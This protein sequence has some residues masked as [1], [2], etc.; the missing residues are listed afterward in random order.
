MVSKKTKSNGTSR[1]NSRKRN[2][3]E[4]DDEGNDDGGEIGCICEYEDDDGFMIQ[5]EQCLVWQ[6]TVCVGIS[7][8]NIPEQYYCEK[9]K[10]R[11]VDRKAA[12]EAQK[13]SRLEM[14][15]KSRSRKNSK[16]IGETETESSDTDKDPSD[17]DTPPAGN[18]L[19]GEDK[20]ERDALASRKLSREEKKLQQILESFA[21]HEE[22]EKR[23]KRRPGPGLSGSES[24]P[25]K[26]KKRKNSDASEN[27]EPTRRKKQ[28]L[29]NGEQ[30]DKRRKEKTRP[31]SSPQEKNNGKE[32]EPESPVQAKPSLTP[33]STPVAAPFKTRKAWMQKFLNETKSEAP[34]ST[35]VEPKVEAK[36]VYEAKSMHHKKKLAHLF[37]TEVAAAAASTSPSPSTSTTTTTDPPPAS[38]PM[39]IE[40]M[41]SI[42]DSVSAA[43]EAKAASNSMPTIPKAESETPSAVGEEVKP[44]PLSP[45]AETTRFCESPLPSPSI[46][47]RVSLQDY[48]KKRKMSVEVPDKVTEDTRI[49]PSPNPLSTSTTSYF[50]VSPAA[51]SI[52]SFS[53]LS[54][55]PARIYTPPPTPST[56]RVQGVRTEHVAELAARRPVAPRME[57]RREWSLQRDMEQQ[58]WSQTQSGRA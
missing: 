19:E 7:Q 8:Q 20:Y 28:H 25:E 9:C 47:T 54:G 42:V 26:E 44:A 24:K 11:P 2:K 27:S 12:N 45:N 56:D 57:E 41:V 49:T 13:Q 10:P 32:D 30:E 43:A 22:R 38:T 1:R 3:D 46:K 36:P 52:S 17:P 58:Q 14:K 15:K 34:S 31:S 5:C 16:K 55:V 4:S 40:E 51:T 29:E 37:H 35:P 23:K 6:H 21:L 18:K 33:P 39:T 53:P 48:K 50:D